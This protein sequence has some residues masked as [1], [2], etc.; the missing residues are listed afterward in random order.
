MCIIGISAYYHDSAAALICDG[1]IIGW[2]SCRIASKH[3]P[4][5]LHRET[6]LVLELLKDLWEFM[7]ARKSIGWF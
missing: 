3:S 4:G 6:F 1:N 7:Q 2:H 5:N